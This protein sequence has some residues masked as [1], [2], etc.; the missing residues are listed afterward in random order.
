M[1]GLPEATETRCAPRYQ[2]QRNLG[3]PAAPYSPHGPGDEQAGVAGSTAAVATIFDQLSTACPTTA[4]GSGTVI[5]ATAATEVCCFCCGWCR[6]FSQL[7]IEF[8][9]LILESPR[10]VS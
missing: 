7:I 1:G 9:H 2:A 5:A 8:Q 3:Q 4:A 6:W 10:R